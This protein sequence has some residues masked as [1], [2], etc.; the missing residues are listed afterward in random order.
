MRS[1][2]LLLAAVPILPA[3]QISSR[4]TSTAQDLGAAG[5][6]TTYGYGLA[7]AKATKRPG[8]RPRGAHAG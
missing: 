2:V 3:T 5:S 8:A 6:D 1:I 7:A 4:L